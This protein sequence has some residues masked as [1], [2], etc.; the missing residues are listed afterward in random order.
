MFVLSY[1]K[2]CQT[3]EDTFENQFGHWTVG[4]VCY[5]HLEMDVDKNYILNSYDGTECGQTRFK[6]ILIYHKYAKFPVYK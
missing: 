3:N 1:G 5:R 2:I 4:K 6:E